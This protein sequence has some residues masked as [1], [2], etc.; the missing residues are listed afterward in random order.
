MKR[1]LTVGLTYTGGPIEGVEID[2]LGLCRSDVSSDHSAFPLYEYDTIIINPASYSHFIFG[3]E[4]EF[5]NA[6]YELSELKRQNDRYDIDSVFDA[7]DRRKEMEAAITKGANVVWCLSH[8][9]RQ[10]FFGYRT[11]HAGYAAADVAGLVTRAD[12]LAKKG[13]RF[14]DLDPNSPFRRYFEA[15]SPTGWALCL[16]D[17]PEGYHSIASTPEGYSLGGR[18]QLPSVAGWL[19]TPPTSSEA[20][21]QLV[22]DALS[23]E[24]SNP[25]L[26]H[27]HSIFLSHTGADKP[28]ARRLRDDLLAH[29]VAK[30]WLDEAEIQIG[31]TLISKIED[32]LKATK[33]IAVILSSKS[34]NAPWVKKELDAAMHREMASGEVVVLPILY[35]KCE[36]PPF[37]TGKLYADFTDPKTYDEVLAKLLRRL[38][39]QGG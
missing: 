1:A 32:G 31:D 2:N 21:N 17:R 9:K 25:K 34:V 33:Y 35:E 38:R 39:V 6:E 23:I 27:Y 24:S 3:R 8:P 29:G 15:L 28:F 13:R 26:D 37:L 4:G 5:S 18:I 11:T 30:V 22:R 20:A 16:R 36:L 10:N 7:S 12:L 14:G 19:I